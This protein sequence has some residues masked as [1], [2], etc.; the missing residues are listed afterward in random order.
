VRFVYKKLAGGFIQVVEED[1]VTRP[2]DEDAALTRHYVES[3]QAIMGG[4]PSGADSR[5]HKS[6]PNHDQRA[7]VGELRELT[8]SVPPKK[9]CGSV[10]GALRSARG[11]FH[12]LSASGAIWFAGAGARSA[13]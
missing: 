2:A 13:V 12:I 4:R 6:R 1:R 8:E 5:G 10:A 7:K 3:M 9:A 11:L